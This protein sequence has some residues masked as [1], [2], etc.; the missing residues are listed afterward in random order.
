MNNLRIVSS[1]QANRPK[2]GARSDQGQWDGSGY[3]VETR[4]IASLP[5]TREQPGADPDCISRET[6][7]PQNTPLK[8]P[9]NPSNGSKKIILRCP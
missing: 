5:H 2:L 1:A 8:F 4:C 6:A 7:W 3:V 9:Y